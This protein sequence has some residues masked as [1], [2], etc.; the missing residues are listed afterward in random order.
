MSP[1]TE[2]TEA[3]E[4]RKVYVY[5]AD[6]EAAHPLNPKVKQLRARAVDERGSEVAEFFGRDVAGLKAAASSYTYPDRV[7]LLWVDDPNGHPA[8]SKLLKGEQEAK[9]AIEKDLDKPASKD[10]Y[11][12]SDLQLMRTQH[13]LCGSCTHGEVCTVGASRMVFDQIVTIAGCMA[14]RPEE[15]DKE[16]E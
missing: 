14:Y 10:R 13:H 1:T 16:D 7:K 6:W 11:E 5:V 9:K 8:L 3:E 2:E 4:A 15:D 12:R